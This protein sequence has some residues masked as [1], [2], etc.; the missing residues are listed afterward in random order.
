MCDLLTLVR[1][2]VIIRSCHGVLDDVGG[3]GDGYR[4]LEREARID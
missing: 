2:C 4:V 3:G 1:R